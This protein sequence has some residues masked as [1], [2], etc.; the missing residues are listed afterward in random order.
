MVIFALTANKI[1]IQFEPRKLRINQKSGIFR[2]IGLP[3]ILLFF[4]GE[5][6]F[7]GIYDGF[8]HCRCVYLVKCLLTGNESMYWVGADTL[9]TGH[10][11]LKYQLLNELVYYGRT[12]VGRS[13][14]IIVR[15]DVS[16]MK[17]QMIPYYLFE[18]GDPI[19]HSAS[20]KTR[21]ILL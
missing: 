7:C 5:C 16:C 20:R 4:K 2:T 11:C 12:R 14:S 1:G 3:W 9:N 10:V 13:I 18:C 8:E 6:N 17:F 15:F 21:A 19:Q